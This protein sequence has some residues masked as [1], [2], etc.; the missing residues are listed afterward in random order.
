MA[1]NLPRIVIDNETSLLEQLENQEED[2][3]LLEEL[4]EKRNKR[5]K[6]FLAVVNKKK[7]SPHELDEVML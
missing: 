7:L 6:S 2:E 3:Q 5:R 4:A 1:R